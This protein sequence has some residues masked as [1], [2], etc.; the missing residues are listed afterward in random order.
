MPLLP[1]LPV[2]SLS[3]LIHPSRNSFVVASLSSLSLFSSIVVWQKML[4]PSMDL[5]KV[6]LPFA[7]GHWSRWLIAAVFLVGRRAHT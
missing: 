1:L 4:D 6:K 5:G 7:V 2:L 3:L